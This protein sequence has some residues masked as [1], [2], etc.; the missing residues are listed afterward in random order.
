MG[1]IRGDDAALLRRFLVVA[2]R[3][4]DDRL[5]PSSPLSDL[6]FM[7]A[8]IAWVL[9]GAQQVSVASHT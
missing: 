8:V 2:S 3:L 4:A 9:T 6:P 5:S 1:G 7:R